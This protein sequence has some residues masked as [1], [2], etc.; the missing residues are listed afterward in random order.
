[1]SERSNFSSAGPRANPLYGGPPPAAKPTTSGGRTPSWV[2]RE[3]GTTSSHYSDSN[4]SPGA[5]PARSGRSNQGPHYYAPQYEHP[6]YTV[7]TPGHYNA[8]SGGPG[9]AAGGSYPSTSPYRPTAAYFVQTPAHSDRQGLVDSPVSSAPSS[10]RWGDDDSRSTRSGRGASAVAIKGG[11]G[12]EEDEDYY[13]DHQREADRIRRWWMG[14]WTWVTLIG[15]L[16][17]VAGAITT[18]IVFQPSE[19]SYTFDYAQVNQFELFENMLDANG[20][21]TDH[22]YANMTLIMSIHNPNTRFNCWFDGG[23]VSVAYDSITNILKAKLPSFKQEHLE[24][25]SFNRSMSTMA[26]PLYAG[27]LHLRADVA[28]EFVPL[29]VNVTFNSHIDVA[30]KLIAPKYA[31]QLECQVN[32]N[33]KT[34]Q[35]LNDTCVLTKTMSML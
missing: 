12:D 32:I 5:S 30:W 33:P 16:L 25:S 20:M 26:F 7:E 8:Y 27:G 22:L 23:H 19:P 35:Y 2:R 31:H 3:G 34:L 9:S 21:P 15:G 11:N 17:L 1:M 10:P 28:E 13:P 4:C 14:F 29:R 18:W 24:W 6:G